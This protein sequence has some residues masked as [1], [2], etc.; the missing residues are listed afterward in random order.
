MYFQ[1][2]P[3]SLIFLSCLIAGI[4]WCVLTG[5]SVIPLLILGTVWNVYI[6]FG[7]TWNGTKILV[8]CIMF[9]MPLL[10]GTSLRAD[11]SPV[12]NKLLLLSLYV[13][14]ITILSSLSFSAVTMKES[15]LTFFQ[16]S[17]LQEPPLRGIIATGFWF[18]GPICFLIGYR[19]ARSSRIVDSCVKVILFSSA[20]AAIVAIVQF[21]TYY[22]VPPIER[23]LAFF[24]I[25]AYQSAI[26]SQT[27]SNTWAWY[28]PTPFCSEPRH[29]AFAMA[30]AAA[31]VMLLRQSNIRLVPSI[32]TSRVWIL[33]YIGL[34]FASASTSSFIGMIIA[35]PGLLVWLYLQGRQ[36]DS[37]KN[38]GLKI[39]GILILAVVL[40][41]TVETRF[42]VLSHRFE[43]YLEGYGLLNRPS[44]WFQS[45]EQKSTA[46]AYLAWLL[47][48]PSA[49]LFGAGP[50]N[51]PFYAYEYFS[52]DTGR[53]GTTMLL[54]SRLPIIESVASIGLIGTFCMAAFWWYCW[55]ISAL[56]LRTAQSELVSRIIVLRGILVF[57]ILYLFSN[58]CTILVWL[59]FGMLFRLS[60]Y[61][62][63]V[64]DIELSNLQ[65]SQAG[66][67]T[68]GEY[69]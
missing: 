47:H 25:Q 29:F 40:L 41:F 17:V 22:A 46:A 34:C 27:V 24:S 32:F 2:A 16:P 44:E 52:Y 11:K 37:R 61:E 31:T 39:L 20:V 38:E 57:L 9:L 3:W 59:I 64:K 43:V 53:A 14:G 49:T 10:P 15:E 55:K 66:L 33:I 62:Q 30:L 23:L 56:S 63:N 50:G 26:T 51:G 6:R 60:T 21:I 5:R 36:A 28:R 4:I 54:N 69:I 7:L 45:N 67:L 58:D 13:I 1:I 42:H 35:L 19:Y 65:W 48:S 12:K 8:L 18:F 68:Y